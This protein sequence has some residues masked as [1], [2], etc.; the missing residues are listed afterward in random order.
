VTSSSAASIA[1]TKPKP[2]IT[3]DVAAFQEALE[4]VSRGNLDKESCWAP[5]MYALN[6]MQWW[7]LC[8]DKWPIIAPLAKK[9]LQLPPSSS[10]CERVWSQSDF[11]LRKTRTRLTEHNADKLLSVYWNSRVLDRKRI[12]I[13][14]TLQFDEDLSTQTFPHS[15]VVKVG[16]MFTIQFSFR[17]LAN[18]NLALSITYIK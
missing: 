15:Q 5:D 16:G 4:E 18:N 10:A 14:S 6:P 11:I 2:S 7:R 1:T 12:S 8:G 9:L 17:R 3:T 13:N